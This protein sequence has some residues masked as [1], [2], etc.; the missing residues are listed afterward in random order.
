VQELEKMMAG[1]AYAGHGFAFA[2]VDGSPIDPG[3]DDDEWKTILKLAGVPDARVHDGRHTAA[4]LLLAQG[5]RLEVV[6]EILGHSDIRVTRGYTHVASAMAR[7]A[8][9]SMGQVLF[10]KPRT[11]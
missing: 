9:D 2:D 11:P 1:G 8:T 5:V 10:K 7:K 3:R 4:T 6:Q